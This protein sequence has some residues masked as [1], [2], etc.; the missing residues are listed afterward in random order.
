MRNYGALTRKFQEGAHCLGLAWCA[1]DI[2]VGDAGEL[3]YLGGNVHFRVDEGVEALLYLAA[4][5]NDCAYLG[6]SVRAGVQAGGFDIKGD[7]LG[8]NGQIAFTVHGERAVN[9]V[10]EVAL[11]AVNYFHAV[12]FARLPHVGECLTDTVVGDGDSRMPPV[13][14][15]LDYLGRLG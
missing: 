13:G 1:L 12:L 8:V 10:D 9:I 2:I 11:N 4:C 3:R 7:H 14:G 6:H 5:E 15:A